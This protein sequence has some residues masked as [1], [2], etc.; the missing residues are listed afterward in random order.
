M[1][2][3]AIEQLS[4]VHDV[5]APISPVHLV[6]IQTIGSKDAIFDHAMKYARSPLHPKWPNA[7]DNCR[8]IIWN[9]TIPSQ[10]SRPIEWLRLRQQ[11]TEYN[12][13]VSV[14][15]QSI[16][17]NPNSRCKWHSLFRSPESSASIL[18]CWSSVCPG[19][20]SLNTLHKCW[21]HTPASKCICSCVPDWSS[22]RLW[23]AN[24]PEGPKIG[25]FESNRLAG[26]LRLNNCETAPICRPDSVCFETTSTTMLGTPLDKR[27]NHSV[28]SWL[29]WHFDCCEWE[30]LKNESDDDISGDAE[31][32]RSLL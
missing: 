31:W 11:E 22:R 10:C 17:S 9:T 27:L 24:R 7:G 14:V 23:T 25:D 16:H 21:L 15:Q 32:I 30:R 26:D 29:V 4:G 8:W 3:S 1:F 6:L 5:P 13:K 2:C 20:L 28:S 12:Y 18:L 19:R